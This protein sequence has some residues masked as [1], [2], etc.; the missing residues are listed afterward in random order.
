MYNK[1][2]YIEM[3]EAEKKSAKLLGLI[4]KAEKDI[5]TNKDLIARARLTIRRTK[6]EGKRERAQKS[7]ARS[8]RSIKNAQKRLLKYKVQYIESGAVVWSYYNPNMP[9][10][11]K[12]H[13]G[14]AFQD[15]D[16]YL[17]IDPE[18]L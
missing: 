9:Y 16:Y 6:L 11:P 4:E 7:I 15:L 12:K 14:Y 17:S 10:E 1:E 13:S 2:A 5:Y 18:V 3:K 8:V